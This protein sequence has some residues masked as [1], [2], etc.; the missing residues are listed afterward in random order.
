M[1]SLIALSKKP[2]VFQ[3]HAMDSTRWDTFRFRPDDIVVGTWAKTG[4]TLVQQIAGQLVFDGA[5]NVAIGEISPW[6]D[7]RIVPLQDVLAL[8]EGQTHRRFVK[9]HLPFDAL[10][11]NERVRYIYV[12][13]D[14]RD[15]IWS[16]HAHQMNFSPLAYELFNNTPGRIGPPLEPPHPNIHE[17]YRI[18]LERDGYPA[19]PFWSHV[20]SWWN[21]RY[22]PNLMLVHFVNLKNDLEGE[23][24]RIAG[25]LDITIKTES[26]PRIVEHC[27]FEY[28]KRH[29]DKAV[30]AGAALFNTGS[31]DFIN[32]GT[33][34]RWRDVL[35]PAE[36]ARADECAAAN[37]TADCARWL[38]TGELPGLNG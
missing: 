14:V 6:L 3:N 32:K 18:W 11:L 27:G 36:I 34:G 21:A 5:D 16:A 4:T 13:R 20:Q 19:W 17:Y 30:G 29:A 35:T 7:L 25:F 23:I 37:L 2:R 33:N 26:W 15:V 1:S 22:L 10:P 12:G 31:R 38:A 24:R 8:L 9:T 28:M